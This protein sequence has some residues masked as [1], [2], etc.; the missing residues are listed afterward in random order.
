[1]TCFLVHGVYLLLNTI[2]AMSLFT[3]VDRYRPAKDAF[4]GRALLCTLPPLDT[5]H[6][7]LLIIDRL[8]NAFAEHRTLCNFLLNYLVLNMRGGKCT[9]GLALGSECFKT[10]I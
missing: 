10:T 7:E 4:A 9:R 3:F 1:M 2:R 8:S 6:K 5:P